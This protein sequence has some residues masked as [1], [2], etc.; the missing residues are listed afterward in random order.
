MGVVG[1]VDCS[2]LLTST[3]FVWELVDGA[4]AFVDGDESLHILLVLL[5]C[6]VD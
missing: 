4:F 1:V 3:L 5:C 6:M 2:F